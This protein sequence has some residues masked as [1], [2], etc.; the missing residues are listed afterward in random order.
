MAV[1]LTELDSLPAKGYIRRQLAIDWKESMDFGITMS[2][3]GIVKMLGIAAFL[4][5]MTYYCW[6]RRTWSGL[7]IAA[8][9]LALFLWLVIGSST[10]NIRVSRGIVD[11]D[12]PLFGRDIP[13]KA[14]DAQ[15]AGVVDLHRRP[16]LMPHWGREGFGSDGFRLGWFH[17]GDG[18]KALVALGSEQ[19]A[20][21]LPTTKGYALIASVHDPRRLIDAVKQDR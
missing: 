12:V 13:I 15:A 16:G 17:L 11:V 21:Y 6:D 3:G 1:P 14:V 19:K 8:S 9:V 4:L 7:G 2:T 5:Y 18:E 10:G 20:V